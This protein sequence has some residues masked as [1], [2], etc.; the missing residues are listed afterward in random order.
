MSSS[1]ESKDEMVLIPK[2]SQVRDSID[3]LIQYV[4]ETNDRDIQGFYEHLHTLREPIIRQQ[5]QSGEQ[6][7]LDS[8][9]KPKPASTVSQPI[10]PTLHHSLHHHHCHPNHSSALF[11][12]PAAV[13]QRTS[14]ASLTQSN[15][16][17]VSPLYGH[18]RSYYSPL[19]KVNKI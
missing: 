17:S 19:H 8:F 18:G 7:K 2:L 11:N 1:S 5:H 16:H 9:F 15:A 13:L 6:L 3:T 12:K 10:S 4:D 14:L